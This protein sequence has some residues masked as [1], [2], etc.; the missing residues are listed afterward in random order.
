MFGQKSVSYMEQTYLVEEVISS[1][2]KEIRRGSN[3][4]HFWGDVLYHNGYWNAVFNRLKVITMEDAS[5][6]LGLPPVIERYYQE[7]IQHMKEAKVKKMSAP[8]KSFLCAF[9]I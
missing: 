8:K 6:Y 9:L 1:L 2:Q 3:K 4:A 5:A 7:G